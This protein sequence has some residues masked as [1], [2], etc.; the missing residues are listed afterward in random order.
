MYDNEDYH[1]QPAAGDPAYS[2]PANS[3]PAY[4]D[5]AANDGGPGYD[6]DPVDNNNNTSG[7]G[8]LY[9]VP[10]S[11]DNDVAYHDPAELGMQQGTGTGTG[12][13]GQAT[14]ANDDIVPL[15]VIDSSGC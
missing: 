3:D 11:V 1:S 7:G 4:N 13:T 5:P 12:P 15:S 2:D 9:S 8:P 10:G 6:N 14:T